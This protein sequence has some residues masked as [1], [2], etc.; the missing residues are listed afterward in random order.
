MLYKSSM[1]LIECFFMDGIFSL[2]FIGFDYNWFI[3]KNDFVRSGH[4]EE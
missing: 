4:K 3:S 1:F 2:I